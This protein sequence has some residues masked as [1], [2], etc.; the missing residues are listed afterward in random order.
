[1]EFCACIST[2]GCGSLEGI[3]L[4]PVIVLA[5]IGA[6]LHIYIIFSSKYLC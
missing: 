1:M 4:L 5:H 6:Y 2:V 3:V